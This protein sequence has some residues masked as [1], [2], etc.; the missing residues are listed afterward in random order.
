MN[1]LCFSF[2]FVPFLYVFLFS[3][4]GLSVTTLPSL[5]WSLPSQSGQYELLIQQQPK[6]HHR[7]HYE[8]EGSRG[9]V[10]TPN[11]GHPEVQVLFL[12]LACSLLGLF[13]VSVQV[14]F[15]TFVTVNFIYR[16]EVQGATVNV[17]W[18]F[19]D[20]VVFMKSRPSCK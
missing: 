9:A 20:N 7:A 15:H 1:K 3:V 4:S 17:G 10:K 18:Y 19:L 12:T 16:N 8:T 11:G 14:A 6:S 2:S 13:C 5:E